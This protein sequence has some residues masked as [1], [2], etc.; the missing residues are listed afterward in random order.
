[1]KGLGASARIWQIVDE[2][3]NYGPAKGIKDLDLSKTIEF[4]NVD[5]RYPTRPDT[6]ILQDL[7]LTIPAQ[8]VLAVVG[9]SGSGTMSRHINHV[10][11]V[12]H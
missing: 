2:S 11:L 7:N 6:L 8:K 1:M 10:C 5:F 9:S 3:P 12:A 4:R